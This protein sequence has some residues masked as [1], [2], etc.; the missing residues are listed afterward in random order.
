[1]KAPKWSLKLRTYPEGKFASLWLIRH[2][3]PASCAVLWGEMVPA[4]A[5]EII[6][7]LGLAVERDVSALEEVVPAKLPGCLPVEKQ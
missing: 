4:L 3:G 2:D 1:V 6:E 5:E 7:G